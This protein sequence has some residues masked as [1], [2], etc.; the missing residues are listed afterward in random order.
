MEIIKKK[1]YRIMTTGT[2]EDC[3]A[4]CRVIIPDLT[5]SYNFKIGLITETKDIG[6]LDVYVPITINNN[7]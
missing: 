2:T 7:E 1:V 6:F 5:V 4:N 3:N